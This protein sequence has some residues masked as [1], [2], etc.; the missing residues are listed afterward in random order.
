M[1]IEV[2]G[3]GNKREVQHTPKVRGNLSKYNLFVREKSKEIRARLQKEM[4]RGETVAQSDVMRECARLWKARQRSLF[5]PSVD[6]GSGRLV[7]R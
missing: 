3:K 1:E 5:E 2:P 4:R 6:S 7:Q